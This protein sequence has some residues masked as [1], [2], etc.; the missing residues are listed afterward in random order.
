MY[1]ALCCWQPSNKTQQVD[2]EILIRRLRAERNTFETRAAQEQQKVRKLEAEL[3][4]AVHAQASASS[5][6]TDLFCSL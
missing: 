2:H 6:A 5:F 3:A 1:V 4:R